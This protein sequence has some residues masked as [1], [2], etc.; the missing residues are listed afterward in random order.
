M[1][2]DATVSNDD[3]LD[4][5]DDEADQTPSPSCKGSAGSGPPQPQDAVRKPAGKG[6]PGKRGGMRKDQ[7]RSRSRRSKEASSAWW[8][9]IKCLDTECK[10]C[11][12][13]TFEARKV[14][15]NATLLGLRW[16][17]LH[18]GGQR[19]EWKRIRDGTADSA[20]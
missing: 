10:S 9:D 17:I 2:S 1:D 20:G 14:V 11:V 6:P 4:D 18:D 3:D 12:V 13:V 5:D 8:G 19:P 7:P 15:L 16:N